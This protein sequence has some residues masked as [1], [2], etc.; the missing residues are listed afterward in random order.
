MNSQARD[1]KVEDNV[2]ALLDRVRALQ[3]M[4]R[5]HAAQGEKDRRVPDAVIEALKEAGAFK[6][7]VPKRYG[8]YEGGMK[9]FLDLSSLVAEADGGTAW[10]TTLVNVCNFF[11]GYYPKAVQD[12]VFGANPG[13]LVSGVL[14][15]TAESRKVEGGYRVSGKW[16]YNS[17]G[18]HTDW[19]GLGIPV[20]DEN[21]QVVD[22]GMA[23]IP[24][25]DLR[26]EDTWFVAGMAA[27][28]SICLIAEDVFV[29][30]ARVMSIPAALEGEYPTELKDS[31]PVYRSALAPVFALVLV[32]PQ[33]GLGRAALDFVKAKAPNKPISYTYLTSQANSVG[34]QLQ[35]AEAAMMIETA[36]LHAYRAAANID[37]AAREGIHPPKEMRARIRADVGLVAEKI[38]GA[39]DI[40][41][42]A[43]GAGSFAQVS[44]LQRIWRDSNVAARH[45]VV[46]PKIAYETY[47]KILLGIKEQV[48]PLI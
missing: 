11:V 44:P 3:P 18:W 40:L 29:P 36:H 32:G 9:A 33:L 5:Q 21:G 14:T 23:L 31:E 15:P 4:I 7:G 47:G 26:I 12:E 48:T 30:E 38:T 13:A 24:S 17:G 43:H 39:I 8:G 20:V 42:S 28:G 34:F 37:D 10:V 41:I 35:I 6:L 16:F 1:F 19:A 2:E 25:S 46:G 45:A 22:Q 27:S